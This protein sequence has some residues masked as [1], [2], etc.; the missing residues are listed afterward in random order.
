MSRPRARCS[1]SANRGVSV[2]GG[3]GRFAGPANGHARAPLAEA[4]VHLC[5][6]QFAPRRSLG[7]AVIGGPVDADAL[8]SLNTD[9]ARAH[10]SESPHSSATWGI[11]H[12]L[13]LL[14]PRPLPGR[15]AAGRRDVSAQGPSAFSGHRPKLGVRGHG[16]EGRRC[17]AR[18]PP[19][20]CGS[21][22][23][24][25]LPVRAR[26][27]ALAE[28]SEDERANPFA[29]DT[30]CVGVRQI[31]GQW[32]LTG[33]F[34][35]S[36]SGDAGHCGS[37]RANRRVRRSGVRGRIGTRDRPNAPCPKTAPLVV[38]DQRFVAHP[39]CVGSL[40]LTPPWGMVGP[41]CSG[42]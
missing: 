12:D 39:S 30:S 24:H 16:R 36:E 31:V 35:S 2:A 21:V 11:V 33:Q 13:P 4:W 1:R 8:T 14:P 40:T 7:A 41:L 6:E 22:A 18:P 3:A 9:V 5:V 42:G 20:D 37:R 19:V 26:I 34:S 29:T 25:P 28:A 38:T 15:R 10:A 32:L 17:R 27:V 23:A